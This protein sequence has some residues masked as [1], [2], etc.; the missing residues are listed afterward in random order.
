MNLSFPNSPHEGGGGEVA[1]LT[2]PKPPNENSD[3]L[4]SVINSEINL[5]DPEFLLN[6]LRTKNSEIIIVGHLNIN[7]IEN[8]CIPIILLLNF[9]SLIFQNIR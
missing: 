7:H 1:N 6:T 3:D 5:E 2:S 9:Q 4:N 8:K